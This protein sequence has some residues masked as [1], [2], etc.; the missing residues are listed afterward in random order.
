MGAA[1]LVY[2]NAPDVERLHGC[3]PARS[4][5]VERHADGIVAML[6]PGLPLAS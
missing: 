2:V 1:S 3:D 6:L 4:D 5:L